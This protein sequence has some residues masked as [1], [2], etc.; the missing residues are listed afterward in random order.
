MALSLTQFEF[1]LSPAFAEPLADF[2]EEEVLS[3]SWT[4]GSESLWD[5]QVVVASAQAPSLSDLILGFFEAHALPTPQVSSRLLPET[6]WVKA[7]YR[8]FP[9][10]TLGR[11][12]VYGSHTEAPLPQDFIPLHINAATAFGSGHHESTEGCLLALSELAEKQAFKA[13]LDM[14]CGSGILALAMAKLW[15][16]PVVACDNDPEAI[17][18]TCHN[19]QL[20]DLENLITPCLSEGFERIASKRFDLIVANILA[21]P[22]CQMAAEA[23]RALVP[24]GI[25]ILSGILT[26]QADEVAQAYGHAGAVLTHQLYRGD[27]STLMLRKGG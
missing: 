7:V 26:R 17:A 6:D 27:W 24:G 19:A 12:Y 22:L 4:E 9:P 15:K 23:L 11:F 5:V 21:G 18:V 16:R 3:V 2:L 10:L 13:P 14:G 8:D 20:N 1:S 25:L